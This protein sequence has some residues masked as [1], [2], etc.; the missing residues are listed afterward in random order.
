MGSLDFGPFLALSPPARDRLEAAA[1]A[2]Q[3]AP[4]E[5]ILREGEAADAAYVILAGKV[6]VQ[7]SAQLRTLATLS[8]PAVVGEMAVLRNEPRMADASAGSGVRALCLPA[9]ALRAAIADEPRFAD[10]LRDFAALRVASNF[11]RRDSPFGDLPSDAISEL[12]GVL[13]AVSFDAGAVSVREGEHGDDA[14]LLRTGDVD[15]V[16]GEGERHIAHLGAGSFIG[17]IS[18][19]TGSA[20][21]ATVRASGPVTAYRLGG[22]DARRI[23]GKY[24]AVVARLESAMQSRHAPRR[25]GRV[26]I[27]DAPDD[28]EC[29]ILYEATSGTYLRLARRGL[30]IYEDLDGTRRL[31][32]IAIRE[33][34]RSGVDDPATVFATVA[35]LQAAGFASAPRITT[36]APDARLI[37]LLDLVLAPRIELASADA[38]AAR[39]HRLF[40]A[41]FGRPGLIA[42]LL[43][44]TLGGIAFWRTFRE[45]TPAD[46]GL[47]G[48]L[49]A[50][51]GL[52]V[53]G[54]GHEA[55]HAIATKVEGRRVGRA[56]VG[57]MFFTPV[58]WVDTSDAWF[59]SRDRRI[60]VNAA[61]PLFNFAFGGILG[62]V[63][64]VTTGRAQD[65]AIWLGVANFVS[66][67]VNLSPL[68]EFDG[69]YVL[70]DLMNVNALRRKALRFVFADLVRHPRMPRT[71]LERGLAVYT[72]ASAAYIIAM[73]LLVLS[74]VPSLVEG[75][76]PPGVRLELRVAAGTV[77]AVV[78][79][80]LLVGPFV[81]EVRAAV[82]TPEATSPIAERLGERISRT[83]LSAGLSAKTS[84]PLT[85]PPSDT[86]RR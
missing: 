20:R 69:Y 8:G 72:L 65:L 22:D 81:S 48:L 17:E 23:I 37:R 7:S 41:L 70:E 68:L 5:L 50:F 76:L 6:R 79:T 36:D 39:L 33:A 3:F 1:S 43:L 40:G 64:A 42:V 24:R 25:V 51:L 54:A 60:A 44:G 38:L 49:V 58:M 46:F 4:G 14:Y 19:L 2:V 78:L 47:G 73:S 34:E 18:A 52:T 63:A 57:L 56:G 66:L 26:S 75:I 9:T 31:R 16:Q 35:T 62:F 82:A 21:T 61:G 30:A 59:V 84:A 77:I 13:T 55:A 11:L 71:G 53:A 27:T 74:G 32:D 86:R 83:D 85:R 28:P 15:V 67:L 80:G 10:E 29:V 45:A 12:A